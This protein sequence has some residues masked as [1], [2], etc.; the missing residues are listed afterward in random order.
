MSIHLVE[1][2]H[3]IGIYT[4]QYIRKH[5]ELNLQS[6]IMQVAR[7]VA[8]LIIVAVRPFFKFKKNHQIGCQQA[9]SISLNF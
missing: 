9:A 7:I 8:L 5:L 1:V 4:L 6:M 3:N 2:M